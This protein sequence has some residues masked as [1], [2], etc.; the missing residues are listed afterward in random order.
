MMNDN[1][2]N[3]KQT[4]E[5]PASR[6]RT[7]RWRY[8][9]VPLVI[10]A[11]SLIITAVFY[12]QLPAETAVRFD[13]SG[14]PKVWFSRT[15]T[16]VLMLVPQVLLALV[17]LVVAWVTA[18]FSDQLGLKQ[19][20]SARLRYIMLFVSNA[21]ALPQFVLFF[22]MLDIFS[23]NAYQQ[24]ILPMWLL[25]AGLLLVVTAALVV[26]I[27]LAIREYRRPV[28]SGPAEKTKESP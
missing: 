15:T 17:S 28:P 22:T 14:I 6:D 19:E 11:L 13:L 16:V 12:R 27:T 5:S 21:V 7:L 10:L 9:I 2:P 24:H 26:F 23:Y 1:L 18:R 3:E 8:F 4:A 20:A 25:L